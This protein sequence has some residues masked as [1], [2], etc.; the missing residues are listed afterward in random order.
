M[1]L[2]TI[3]ENNNQPTHNAFI[4]LTTTQN[5]HHSY[6]DI[7]GRFPVQSAS[8]NQYMFLYYH[9]DA[10]YIHAVPIKSRETQHITGAW[11]DTND[12][13]I[14]QGHQPTVHI[15]DN[16][17]SRELK[18][19]FKEEAITFQ[20]LPPYVH[21][22]NSAER[23]IQTWKGHFLSGLAT[24]NPKFP[25]HQWDR[26]INQSNITLNLLRSSRIHAHLSS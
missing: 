23:A 16:E 2:N 22:R 15:L 26:L 6:S 7:I 19:S 14:K 18:L 25:V 4:T 5:I 21:R 20:L 24:S 11:K 9:Y 1:D 10:N 17:C 8:G 13:F 3:Q 12:M